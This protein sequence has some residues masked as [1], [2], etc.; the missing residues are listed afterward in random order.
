MVSPFLRPVR[1]RVC[2]SSPPCGK[3]QP[4]PRTMWDGD[5]C[6]QCRLGR[7][8]EKS[9]H[10]SWGPPEGACPGE[11]LTTV[12]GPQGG[13]VLSQPRW[14][15][16]L[17]LGMGRDVYGPQ[18]GLDEGGPACCAESPTAYYSVGLWG[19]VW[20]EPASG[21]VPHQGGGSKNGGPGVPPRSATHWLCNL[22]QVAPPLWASVSKGN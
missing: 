14:G 1:A 9:G 18:D 12:C 19:P 22:R 17:L 7:V 10:P 4:P 11:G 8:G 3:G 16:V 6:L 20:E 2:T 5:V 15:D 21:P 13:Q